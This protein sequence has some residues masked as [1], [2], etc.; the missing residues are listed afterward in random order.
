MDRL[1]AIRVFLRVAET[2]SF[3]AAAREAGLGQPA[4]SK[5]IA[6]L[7]AHLGAQLLR[8]TSRSLA[9]TEAGEGFYE[10]CLRLIA[11]LDT[12]ESLVGRGRLLPSGLVRV[13]VA[14]VFGRLYV[15]PLLPNFLARY[16]DVS[17][18]I[19]ASRR[20]VDLVEDGVDVAV[21]NGALPN[22]T[23]VARTLGASPV[24]TVASPAYLAARG[25]PVTPAD[26]DRH[27]AIVFVARGEVRPW[28]FAAPGG[29]LLLHPRGRFRTGDAEQTR[30]AVLAGLGL[31]QS[32]VWL[33]APDLASGAVRPVLRGSEPPPIPISLV[34]P[35]DRRLPARV[36]VFIDMVAGELVRDPRLWSD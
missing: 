4:V 25:E 10:A 30:A 12:A 33:F 23:L 11:D 3:S 24:V 22:S 15:T 7:E 6:A 31:A 26:L 35:A 21:R 27:D 17:V 34:R 2:G 28:T 36:R 13:S 5:Q 18:E 19:T 16:P 9:L 8:R 1:D 20:A 32:P 14:P 29:P